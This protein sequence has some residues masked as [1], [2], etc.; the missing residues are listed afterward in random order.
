M[1][2]LSDLLRYS[3]YDAKDILVPLPEEINYIKN[4]IDFEKIR[5]GE[6]LN[7]KTDFENTNPQKSFKIAPMLLIVFVE[8]AFKHS[9]NSLDNVIN[10]EMNL[11]IWGNSILF[12]VVNS[13][14]KMHNDKQKHSGFGL[15]NVKKRLDLIYR[16][17][18][19]LEINE[20][21]TNYEVKLR[22]N[23]K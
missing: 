17:E 10:I 13:H 12:S 15:D 14:N 21:T 11:K 20:T 7:L 5:L 9:K 3:V 1:L 22:I 2:K 16:G 18:Y 23:G 4:Y 8:N 19:D 6:R